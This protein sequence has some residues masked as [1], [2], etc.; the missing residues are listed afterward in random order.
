MNEVVTPAVVFCHCFQ[1]FP[2]DSLF[3]DA[4]TAPFRFVLEDLVRELIDAGSGFSRAGVPGDEPAAA[5]LVAFP[6]QSLQSRDTLRPGPKQAQRDDE[7][8][9]KGQDD[10]RD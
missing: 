4:K 8:E 1:R 9:A 6:G 5:K 10:Y 7:P 3:V 2:I